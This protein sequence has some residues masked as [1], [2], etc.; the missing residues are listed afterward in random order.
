[1]LNIYTYKNTCMHAHMH[2]CSFS[3]S[4]ISP[5]LPHL[6]LSSPHLT[7]LTSPSP[8]VH[9]P[10]S[11]SL[12]L[13]SSPL[14]LPLLPHLSLFCPPSPFLLPHFLTFHSPYLPLP[15]SSYVPPSSSLTSPSSSLLQLFSPPPH[16]S[17]SIDYVNVPC[18][19]GGR[20]CM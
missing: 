10:H 3:S 5:Y 2:F 1:M 15:P 13:P 6:S 11:L 8:C 20:T 7:S 16:S 19:C 17:I 4:F 14:P 12:P 9:L 18:V